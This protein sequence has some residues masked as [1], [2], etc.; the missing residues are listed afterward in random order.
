[1][2]RTSFAK[3][4]GAA[5]VLVA[6]LASPAAGQS[7]TQLVRMEIRPISQIAV[8][9]TTSF[10]I[11][12]SQGAVKPGVTTAVASYAVTTNEENRRIIVAIDEPL[13]DGVS[14]RM[15]MDAPPGAQSLDAVTL[16]TSPQSA[17]AGISMLNARELGIAYELV[18]AT[19]VVVPAATKRTVRVTL[20]T[21]T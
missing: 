5:V 21:G 12:A 16:S 14:L 20:V 10:T 13:P 15:R 8:V 2:E 7:A 11:A 6:V 1:M 3:G 18:T 17:V 19:G 9:G 4:L